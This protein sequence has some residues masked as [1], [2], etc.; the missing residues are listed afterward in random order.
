MALLVAFGSTAPAALAAHKWGSKVQKQPATDGFLV[1]LANHADRSKAINDISVEAAGQ[2]VR[3][4]HLDSQDL[5]VLHVRG[6]QGQQAQ[7]QAKLLSMM[8]THPEIKSVSLNHM[9]Y[10]L[11]HHSGGSSP[12]PSSQTSKL[13]NDPELL[14]QWP[15]AA[16]RWPAAAATFTGFQRQPAT[17]TILSSGTTPVATNGELGSASFEH[18]FNATGA[19]VRSIVPMQVGNGGDAEGD[20][21]S[22]ITACVTNNNTLMA[23]AANFGVKAPCLITMLQI[24]TGDTVPVSNII[25]GLIWAGNNQKTR[26]GRGPINVSYG[27]PFGQAPLWSDLNI[28]TIATALLNQGDICVIAAGDSEGTYLFNPPGNVVVVQG[29]DNANRYFSNY[30][31]TIVNDPAGAPGAPQ[32]A[33]INGQFTEDFYGSSF[34]APLW[35]AAIAMCISMNPQLSSL[36][37]HQ[38]VVKTG[39]PI[40]NS[41]WYAVVPAFD[42]AMAQAAGLK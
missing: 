27:F 1:V 3:D 9:A 14:E 7:T 10:S 19:T 41:Q 5:S 16:M 23:G 32:P 21:D 15:L 17:I 39:T 11:N 34:S 35:C 42:R 24:T 4:M 13:P 26:G 28:Q 33:V 8:Q 40:P 12:P 31:N 25:N 38:I 29:T 18:Q 2:T 30:E 37:A 20:I 36:Q 22:S 6:P